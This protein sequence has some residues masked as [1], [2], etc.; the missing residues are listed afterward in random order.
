MQ[1]VNALEAE[2]VWEFPESELIIATSIS[3]LWKAK[4]QFY[5]VII[6]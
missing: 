2:D 6:I 1:N 3:A 4:E 5:K